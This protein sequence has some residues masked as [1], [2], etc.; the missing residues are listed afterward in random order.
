[1]TSIAAM[2]SATPRGDGLSLASAD[3]GLLARLG[4]WARTRRARAALALV[5]PRL[6][7]DAGIPRPADAVPEAHRWFRSVV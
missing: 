3:H 4:H 2:R 5:D 6:L 7:E 1:M